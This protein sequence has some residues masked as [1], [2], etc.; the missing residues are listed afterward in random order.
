MN[1]RRSKTPIII[2]VLVIVLAILSISLI[3]ISIQATNAAKQTMTSGDTAGKEDASFTAIEETSNVADDLIINVLGDRDTYVLVNEEYLEAGCDVYDSTRDTALTDDVVIE[4][5]VDTS[6]PGDYEIVYTATNSTGGKATASR[7]V[8]VVSDMETA[9]SV[10]V[11]MY[12]YVYTPDDMP[13][14]VTGNHILQS[15]LEEQLKYLTDQDYYYPSYQ[16]LRAF[17]DGD[18]SLPA[19]SVILTFD[20]ADTGFL[21]YGVPL[22][23]EYKIPA[24]SFAVGKDA[25]YTYQAIVGGSEY[26]TFQSHSYD[27]HRA[28]SNVGRGGRIHALTKEELIE[29]ARLAKDMLKTNDAMAYPFG[30]NNENAWEALSDEGYLCAFTIVDDRVRPND[31]PMALN[32]VRISGGNSLD[33]FATRVAPSS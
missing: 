1:A 27:L 18:R 26:V 19:K 20:D 24:T 25:P 7:T 10:P 32:R 16:E 11:L 21:K 12:H 29:D 31:N 5:E 3:A 30:D 6:T 2:A 8:H 9:S 17:V 15:D 22:F 23:E 13:D 4:G 33:S 14:E 28:G